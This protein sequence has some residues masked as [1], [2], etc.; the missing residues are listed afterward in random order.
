MS[1]SSPSLKKRTIQDIDDDEDGEAV[2]FQDRVTYYEELVAAARDHFTDADW[3][4]V[5]GGGP[6][7]SEIVDSEDLDALNA[8]TGRIE[9]TLEKYPEGGAMGDARRVA[10]GQPEDDEEERAAKSELEPEVIGTAD[11]GLENLTAQSLENV[12]EAQLVVY[13][14]VPYGVPCEFIVQGGEPMEF[15]SAEKMNEMLNSKSPREWKDVRT[16][17]IWVLRSVDRKT[18]ADWYSGKPDAP[19]YEELPYETFMYIACYVKPDPNNASEVLMAECDKRN[20]RH[21]HRAVAT[22][23]HE[24]FDELIKEP[25]NRAKKSCILGWTACAPPQVEPKVARWPSYKSVM[26]TTAYARRASQPRPKGA[27]KKRAT[28]CAVP[29]PPGGFFKRQKT[30]EESNDGIADDDDDED[31]GDEGSS[32]TALGSSSWNNRSVQHSVLDVKD[33]AKTH[34]YIHNNQV[35]VIEH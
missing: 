31:A 22:K 24:R 17:H 2:S 33:G 26:L 25:T 3:E 8:M 1:A 6:S 7:A 16:K 27:Q 29:A 14:G 12:T 35:H 19:S 34:V 13:S 11:S 15:A 18:P 20:L 4:T 28:G 10:S 30:E 5:A 23:L 21:L 32:S 9:A